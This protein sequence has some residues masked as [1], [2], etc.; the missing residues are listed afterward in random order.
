M[1]VNIITIVAGARQHQK[2]LIF[3]FPDEAINTLGFHHTG[4]FN[5]NSLDYMSTSE[6][7]NP[8]VFYLAFL[9]RELLFIELF[10]KKGE[11]SKNE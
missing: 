4:P 9:M 8:H 5:A 1:I 3:F 10:N 2:F 11:R 7:Y 6:G